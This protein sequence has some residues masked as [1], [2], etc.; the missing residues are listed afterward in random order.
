MKVIVCGA[1]QVGWQIARHLSS[2]R[3][4][5][6]IVDSQPEL[7]RRAT[8]A[9]DVQ[10]VVGYASHPTIL[11]QAGARDADMVIAATYSDEVNMV[12]CQVAHSVFGVTRKIAR[13]REQSYLD[14]R[15]S[16]LFRRE[17]LPIDVIISPEREV[18]QAAL[19]R[20]AYPE[21]FDVH[22]FF[23]GKALLIGLTLDENCAVLNTSLRQLSDLFPTLRI[24]VAGVRRGKR[25]FAPEAEDQLFVGDSIYILVDARDVARSF[26]VFG[27][28]P[29]RQERVLIV[30]GGNVGLSVARILE[31]QPDRVRVKV[32]ERNRARAEVAADALERSIVLHGDGMDA[33]LLD[34]AG[35]R[36]TDAVLLLTDD[37]RTNLLA[38]VRAKTSGAKLAISLINDPGMVSLAGAMGIDAHINPRALTVSSILRH[39]RHGRVRSVYL[40]G[41]R[42]AEVIEAQV[43]GT[44]KLSNLRVRDIEFPEGAL[45]IG[46]SRKGEFMRPTGDIVLREGDLVVIFSLT[47]DVPKVDELLQVAVEFF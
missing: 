37:D 12:T 8:D 25:L 10:G 15:Y 45:L 38:A 19:K 36:K 34:E 11:Q 1:G 21:A 39:V 16:D 24:M 23:Q 27:K 29:T 5:V 26:E 2:E 18:S 32:I 7:V 33:N 40:L 44:S 9:L 4:D 46:I 41:D 22:E 47:E 13:L 17:H 20:V 42:E 31:N 6:T 28:T 14:P 35:I 3:N 30:G 43:L